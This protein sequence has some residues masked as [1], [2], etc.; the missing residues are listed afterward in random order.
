[1]DAPVDRGLALSALGEG[2]ALQGNHSDSNDAFEE[3]V[4]LLET[5]ERWHHAAAACTAWGRMLRATGSEQRAMDVLERAAELGM[6][7]TPA[8]AHAER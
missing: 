8:S 2:L 4:D 3:A 5:H 6:R 7:T 1:M